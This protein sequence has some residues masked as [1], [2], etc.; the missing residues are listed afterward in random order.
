MNTTLL[1]P[2]QIGLAACAFL[3]AS[4]LAGAASVT[5]SLPR[6]EAAENSQIQVAISVREAQGLGPLQLDLRYD[7][8]VL[9]FV[10]ATEGKGPAVGLFDSNLLEPG[11]VRLAM[12]GDPNQPIQGDGELFLVT[13][14]VLGSV[15]Q[16]SA[17]TAENV[18]AW[19]Q[20]Q[21]AFDMKVGVEPGALL[22]KS[23]GLPGW[24]IG[25][26]IVL[27]AVILAAVFALR[28]RGGGKTAPPGSAAAPSG[29]DTAKS[30]FCG[31]CGARMAPAA[32]FC[33]SC[34]QARIA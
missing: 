2:H 30:V 28:K 34:G 33:P 29:E 18:R 31:S 13:F 17:L 11:N 1:S 12:T 10:N 7:P 23:G 15:G 19:E 5:I 21:E 26:G 27:L 25:A 3:A 24:L 22:V 16:T 14:R 4:G 9:Q 8:A 20:T 6:S 32:K